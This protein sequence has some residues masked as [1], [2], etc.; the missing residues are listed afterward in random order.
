LKGVSP[1]IR[2]GVCLGLSLVAWLPPGSARAAEPSAA[3]VK[4][5]E[6]P[7]TSKSTGVAEKKFLIRPFLAMDETS[8]DITRG[9]DTVSFVPNSR[10]AAGARVGYSGFSLSIS[11]DVDDAEDAS[12]YGTSDY[13]ALSAGRAFRIADRELFVSGFLQYHEGLYVESTR[14]DT[15]APIVLPEL[16]VFTVGLTATYYL[17]PEF[18][19]DATFV[20]FLPRDTSIG[21]WTFRLSTGIMGF[22]NAGAPVLPD[23]ARA[24]F[25]DVATLNESGA[26]YVGAMGGYTLDLRL[27]RRWFFAPALLLGATF[28]REYYQTAERLARGGSIAGAAQVAFALGYSGDTLHTGI[29][30]NVDFEGYDAGPAEQSIFRAAVMLFAGVRF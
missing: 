17:N 18:S 5:G 27:W 9:D 20:E 29:G 2:A 16:F 10:L 30:V 15:G 24:R 21:S 25:G 3:G 11:F 23:A 12:V 6:P 4:V 22:D 8:L 26:I 7:E 14:S 1:V 28:A 19:Y 13:L